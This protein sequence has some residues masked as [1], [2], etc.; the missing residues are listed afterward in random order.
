MDRA[1]PS[2]FRRIERALVSG[3]LGVVVFILERIVLRAE[4]KSQSRC[5]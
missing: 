5:T 3:G 4:R 1:K 2:L